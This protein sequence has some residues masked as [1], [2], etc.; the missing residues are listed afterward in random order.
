MNL[1][2]TVNSVLS[3]CLSPGDN[4]NWN[5]PIAAE[6]NEKRTLWNVVKKVGIHFSRDLLN[7]IRGTA[8]D[9]RPSKLLVRVLRETEQATPPLVRK[10]VAKLL[11]LLNTSQPWRDC[12]IY[13]NLWVHSML[14]AVAGLH[15]EV[16]FKRFDARKEFPPEV[17]KMLEAAGRPIAVGRKMTLGVGRDIDK[18]RETV[19]D[20]YR[21]LFLAYESLTNLL[22]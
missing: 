13:R 16:T 1:Q 17:L 6:R 5:L 2:R 4:P 11:R 19:Q 18:L 14:P 7:V 15:S 10:E 21:D 3:V 9:K 22:A 20:A 8:E 12:I